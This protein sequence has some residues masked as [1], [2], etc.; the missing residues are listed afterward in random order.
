MIITALAEVTKISKESE[1]STDS[2]GKTDWSKKV[3]YFETVLNILQNNNGIHGTIL[4]RGQFDFGQV[5]KISVDFSPPMAVVQTVETKD[6][7]QP[8]YLDPAPKRFP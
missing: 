1:Y 8:P 3:E 5:F 6:D 4:V 7:I 2:K